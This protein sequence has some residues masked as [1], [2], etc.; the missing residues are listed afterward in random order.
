MN[1]RNSRSKIEVD[2]IAHSIVESETMT[3]GYRIAIELIKGWSTHG[4]FHFL[5]HTTEEGRKMFRRYISENESIAY[6]VSW[7]PKFISKLCLNHALI[8]VVL[9]I[10]MSAV[11]S[12]KAVSSWQRKSNTLV[13]S[14]TPFLPDLMPGLLTKLKS[15]K[16]NWFVSHAMF[17]PSIF[18]GGF[19]IP[20]NNKI[21]SLRDIGFYVNEK[22]I[23]TLIKKHADI[24]SETNELDRNRC[25][26]EGVPPSRVIVIQGGIDTELPKRIPEPKTKGFDAV[27][28]GR[29][30]PQKGVLELIEIWK[31]VCKEKCDAKLA[32]IGNG[33]L[34][35]DIR[36][37]I[38]K[39]GLQNNITLFGFKDGIDKI[40]IFKNSKIVVHPSLYDSGG[41]AACEAMACGLPGVSFDLP[42][43]RN[44]YP[45]GM[46]KVKCFNLQSFANN[47]L[48]LLDN[49]ELYEKTKK[50]AFEL[51][52]EWDWDRRSEKV[53]DV[54]NTL[55]S[56]N[57]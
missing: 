52:N 6:D 19:G 44:Y 24:I 10:S 16:T 18:K 51:A 35:Q 20:K 47:I 21:P 13:Y 28:V 33:P 23:Y 54:I 41:M 45:H 36:K 7:S 56:N 38:W 46:L 3:G 26:A 32:L 57:S 8:S 5:I 55:F 25:I 4:G 39:D 49:R 1:K 22:L 9:Y 37:R 15:P 53:L 43:L 12:I 27:F 48:K 42:A 31:L 34:E 40:M 11:G 29:L 50:D 17:A 14:I 30:H 2:V